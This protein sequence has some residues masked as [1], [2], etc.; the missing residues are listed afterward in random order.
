MLSIKIIINN[1]IKSYNFFSNKRTIED[2]DP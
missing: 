2:E 1:I